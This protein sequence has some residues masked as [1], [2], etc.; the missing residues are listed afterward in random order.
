MYFIGFIFVFVSI[1]LGFSFMGGHLTVLFQP[2]EFVIILGSS[3]G[4]FISANRTIFIKKILVSVKQ[5]LKDDCLKRDAYLELLS[6]LYAIFKLSRTK[7]MI[8][9]E[10]HIENPHESTIFQQYPTFLKNHMAVDLFCDYMRIISIGVEDPMIIDDMMRDEVD[11]IKHENLEKVSAMNRL[12]DAL[13]ALGIVAAVLGMIHTMGSIDQP[14][15]KL[16][17][18]IGGALV[19]TFF[20]ILVSYGMVSPTAMRM[21]Q[22]IELDN[23]Y[24]DCI[25]AGIIAYMNKLPPIIAAEAARKNIDH[26]F[27]PTYTEM[28]TALNEIEI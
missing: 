18:L 8:A 16:G 14:P 17:I 20:G 19:G 2:F 28:E 11:F 24:Y 7:S 3:I 5:V 13:P 6:V 22:I 9:I 4:A 25:K 1:G 26:E 27:R 23:K 12:A 10:K 15:E 21:S